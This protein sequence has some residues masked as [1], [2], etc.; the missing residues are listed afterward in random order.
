M[1]L[2]WTCRAQA[3]S[4]RDPEDGSVAGECDGERAAGTRCT[5]S[6]RRPVL[7]GHSHGGSVAMYRGGVSSGANERLTADCAGPSLFSP[8]GSVDR[9]LSFAAGQ[10]ICA[11]AAVVSAVGADA[12][13][14]GEWPG[15]GAGIRRSGWCRIARTCAPAGTVPPV[16]AE[17]LLRTWHT[18]MAE[19]RDLMKCPFRTPTV[20]LIWGDHDRAVPVSTAESLKRFGCSRVT[21]ACLRVWD[22][23]LRKSDRS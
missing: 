18:D 14:G 13:A 5:G 9:V 21:C 22:T 12:W 19:L 10:S 16:S 3:G 6:L 23:G 20:M 2:R 11:H 4:E 7:V 8:C 1:W 17:E 15:Q